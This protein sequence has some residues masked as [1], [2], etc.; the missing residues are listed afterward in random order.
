MVLTSGTKLSPSGIQAPLTAGGTGEVYRACDTRLDRKGA[1][2]ILSE[3]FANDAYRLQRFVLCALNNPNLLFILDV[4]TQGGVHYVV[5]EFL[6]GQTLR[7]PL[8]DVMTGYPAP[9]WSGSSEK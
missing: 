8:T 9:L 5:S 1:V 3:S 4:G 2:K 6:K 7:D